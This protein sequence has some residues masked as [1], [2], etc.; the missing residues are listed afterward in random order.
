[1]RV[2]K[3]VSA[4][5]LAAALL[6]AALAGCGREAGE[7]AEPDTSE[8]EMTRPAETA[9]QGIQT[10]LAV[11]LSDFDPADSSAAFRNQNQADMLML[12]V[13]DEARGRTT[14]VQVNPDTLVSFTPPGKTEAVEIPLGQVYS[15]GSAGSDSCL[16]L[17]KAVSEL[18]G[19]IQIDYYMIFAQGAIGIVSDVMGGLEVIVSED[20]SEQYPE[21]VPGETAL[22]T[23][24]QA[25]DF[26]GFR[27]DGD[28]SNERRMARQQQFLTAVYSPFVEHM[29]Q[30]DFLTRLTMQLGDRLVTDLALSQMVQLMEQMEKS[31]LAE[32]IVTL[33]GRVETEDGGY[34][35]NPEALDRMTAELFD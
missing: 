8:T 22:L 4:F 16:A 19:G 23:G 7:T 33:P 14:A 6:A 21:F 9:R 31:E 5:F 11:R 12:M 13:V 15:Y 27:D 32:T 28:V 1:M 25:E 34:R 20:F 26:F 30:D 18:L 2:S 24:E 29:Q 10:M 35:V 3:K 17:R